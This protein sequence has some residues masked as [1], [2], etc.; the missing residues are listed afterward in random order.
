[1]PIVT[2]TY[3]TPDDSHAMKMAMFSREA[4]HAVRDVD[5]SL[6][7]HLRHGEPDAVSA[8]VMTDARETLL[9]VLSL[10]GALGVS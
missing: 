8:K 5:A 9:G 3:K 2:M 1:M 4:F 7:L 10:V 6:R